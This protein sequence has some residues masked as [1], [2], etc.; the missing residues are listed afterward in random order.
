M[1]GVSCYAVFIGLDFIET[2]DEGC[3]LAVGG[4]PFY[5]TTVAVVCKGCFTEKG[6]RI[7]CGILAAV[8]TKGGVLPGDLASGLS[9]WDASLW[10]TNLVFRPVP[11][12]TVPESSFI[13]L[14]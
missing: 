11:F 1:L 3:G 9:F 8:Y 4:N 12:R 7:I 13:F 5:S 6:R 10:Y 2:S 14:I